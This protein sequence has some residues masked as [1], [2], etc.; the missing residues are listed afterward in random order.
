[1]LI[2][3]N[4]VFQIQSKIHAAWLWTVKNRL[5][6]FS[7]NKGGQT[8]GKS[9]LQPPSLTSQHEIWLLFLINRYKAVKYYNSNQVKCYPIILFMTN[10]VFIQILCLGFVQVIITLM[11]VDCLDLFS[12]CSKDRGLE[13]YF[14]PVTKIATRDFTTPLLLQ[15]KGITNCSVIQ[16]YSVGPSCFTH[17]PIP[18]KDGRCFCQSTTNVLL[19]L[20]YLLNWSFVLCI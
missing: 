2:I 5:G 10:F 12:P 11:V 16:V 6:M 13:P 1:M 18:Y 4:Y 20:V 19:R 8:P 9:T 15:A 14:N 17:K 3:C 7:R